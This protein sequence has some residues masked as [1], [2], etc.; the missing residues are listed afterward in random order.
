MLDELFGNLFGG[1]I[2]GCNQNAS[3]LAAQA[4]EAIA[5]ENAPLPRTELLAGIFWE[6]TGG[7]THRLTIRRE[8]EWVAD[9]SWLGGHVAPRRRVAETLV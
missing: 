8:P 9:W 2:V 3:L 4:Q 1:A 7:K 5:C 6:Q